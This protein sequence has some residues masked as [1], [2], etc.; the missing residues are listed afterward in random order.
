[1]RVGGARHGVAGLA[2]RLAEHRHVEDHVGGEQAQV[3]VGGM[4]VVHRDRRH[5]SVERKHARMVGHDERR[6]LRGQ[7]LDP[8][9]LD[10]EPV[11]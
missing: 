7:V 4:L 5:Q 3:A 10:P 11:T 8:A 6:T 2:R 1:M 9:D